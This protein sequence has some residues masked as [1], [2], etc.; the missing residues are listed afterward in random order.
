M[1]ENQ[2]YGAGLDRVYRLALLAAGSPRAA[3][4]LLRRAFARRDP[5]AASAEAS[6]AAGLLAARPGP[7][8]WRP[9]PA[10][11]AYSG[12]TPAELAILRARLSAASPATR[13]ALGA[14]HVAAIDLQVEPTAQPVPPATPWPRRAGNRYALLALLARDWG[15]LPAQVDYADVYEQGLHLGGELAPEQAD[16]LRSLLLAHSPAAEQSRAVREGLRRAEARLAAALPALFGGEAPAALRDDLLA[17]QPSARPPVRATRQQLALVAAVALIA[18]AVIAL[19]QRAPRPGPR[20]AEPAVALAEPEG[21]AALLRAALNRL[22]SPSGAGVRHE[23]FAAEA[24]GYAWSLER[25]QELAPPHRF[26]VEVRDEQ[27]RLRYAVASDGRGLVQQ[28]SSLERD[29][30]LEGGDYTLDEQSLQALLPTLR[31]QPDSL[32]LAGSFN[33]G[34]NLERYYLNLAL[35]APLRDLGATQAAGRPAQLLAFE[36][37]AP[38]PPDPYGSFEIGDDRPAQVILAI[39]LETKALLEARVLPPEGQEAGEV[40]RPWT[41]ERFELLA[42]LPGSR[43]SLPPLAGG[44]QSSG[45][46]V[47]ARLHGEAVAALRKLTATEAPADGGP[48]YFP[49]DGDGIGYSLKYE[50]GW[51]MLVRETADEVVQLIPFGQGPGS[52]AEGVRSTRR[53]G[54]RVYDLI[55]LEELPP[56]RNIS[57]AT[58]FLSADRARGMHLIYSHAYASQLE[59]E[60]RLD[61]LIRSLAPLEVGG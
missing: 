61:A 55:Y 49:A 53:A 36:S 1:D 59:R 35:E 60:A 51:T 58:I 9:D 12:L 17:S 47:S 34:F 3:T 8:R 40:R 16:E 19:P 2:L 20:S 43:F 41:V 18:V 7:W 29:S 52:F 45:E 28:R 15:L 21:T 44:A 54:E 46:L 42:S 10:A 50:G 24:E 23:R 5:S 56:G 31:Q 37:A 33:P 14:A 30:A 6:L 25:W 11:A 4:R 32:V 39:D 38:F 57:L 22:D 13:L 48:L 26:R 27:D